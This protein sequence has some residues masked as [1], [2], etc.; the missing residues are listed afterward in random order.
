MFSFFEA[1]VKICCEFFIKLVFSAATDVDGK[2]LI[3]GSDEAL[4]AFDIVDVEE[5][6][7]TLL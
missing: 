5:M 3:S 4:T 1:N 6:T 2:G 7:E